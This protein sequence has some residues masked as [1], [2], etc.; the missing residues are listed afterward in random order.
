MSDAL[1]RDQSETWGSTSA[2]VSVSSPESEWL[3]SYPTLR[4]HGAVP[5]DAL[6]DIVRAAA[7]ARLVVGGFEEQRRERRQ[8]CL[9]LF[10]QLLA[11]A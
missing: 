7:D 10:P 9:Q 3:V 4:G 11:R 2:G 8:A 6:T 1:S 5:K